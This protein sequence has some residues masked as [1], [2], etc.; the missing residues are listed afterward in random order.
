M[1][2]NNNIGQTF[3]IGFQYTIVA[4]ADNIGTDGLDPNN[5]TTYLYASTNDGNSWFLVDSV[6]AEVSGGNYP[7]TQDDYESKTGYTVIS[8]ITDVTLVKF[9]GVL[10]CDA[11]RAGKTGNVSVKIDIASVD[12]GTTEIICDNGF[13]GGCFSSAGLYCYLTP[14]TSTTL[15]PTTSTTTTTTLAPSVNT[16]YIHIPII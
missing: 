13:A 7:I 12:F 5:N 2:I 9:K 11:G 15:E 4:T 10:S 14:T 1:G 3:T 8:D 6:Y 16:L